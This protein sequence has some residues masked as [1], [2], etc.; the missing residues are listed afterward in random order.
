MKRKATDLKKQHDSYT[1]SLEEYK[2]AMDM[3]QMKAQELMTRMKAT[4]ND[5]VKAG[6]GQELETLKK[7][8]E[9]TLKLIEQDKKDR[10]GIHEQLKR[11][12]QQIHNG[13]AHIKDLRLDAKKVE[14]Q[15]VNA[16]MSQTGSESVCEKKKIQAQQKQ[17]EAEKNIKKVEDE[18]DTIQEKI[19]A[20]QLKLNAHEL[21]QKESEEV[22][23]S[24]LKRKASVEADST[25]GNQAQILETIKAEIE[26]EQGRAAEEKKNKEALGDEI[27]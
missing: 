23:E 17:I 22:I 9:E 25:A 21:N 1:M 7:E 18:K 4:S 19:T 3:F 2:S 6:Y 5:T 20:K 13:R 15:V 16:I 10:K 8:R 27:K 24:L 11:V 12:K 26:T 14:D